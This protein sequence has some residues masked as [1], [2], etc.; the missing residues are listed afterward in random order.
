MQNPKNNAMKKYNGANCI[1][2]LIIDKII[3][4]FII[5][6]YILIL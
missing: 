6:N 1:Y 2:I 4:F 3:H 5:I